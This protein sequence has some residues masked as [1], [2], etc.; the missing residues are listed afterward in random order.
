[1]RTIQ[2]VCGMAMVVAL[3]ACQRGN[4]GPWFRGDFDAALAAAE[5][6]STMV[7]LDFYSDG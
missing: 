4:E 7:F 2:V 3:G 5:A 6:R 1:M